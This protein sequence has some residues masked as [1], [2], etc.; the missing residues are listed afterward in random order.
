VHAERRR[1]HAKTAATCH[2]TAMPAAAPH[3]GG[4]QWP[5]DPPGTIRASLPDSATS[6]SSTLA[7]QFLL[8]CRR[9]QLHLDPAGVFELSRRLRVRGPAV[10]WTWLIV[11]T[12][13]MLWRCASPSSRASTRSP[14]SVY[15]WSNA[16]RR[17]CLLDDRLD[18]HRGS[19]VTVAA[20]AVAWQI[21]LPQVS[22]KL[23]DLGTKADA[24]Y[25]YTKGGPRTPCCSGR[26]SSWSRRSST[27]SA[28][29]S[30][31]GSTLRACSPS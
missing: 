21:V 1:S 16:S 9:L 27:C 18:L 28:S 24:G 30:W 15:Q 5:Q 8:V 23:P 25:Y 4:K 6:R 12:G 19:I 31:R 13:Q 14:V 10:W 29:G 2:Q 7:G 20:V 11:F 22:T 26:S 3:E 17:L